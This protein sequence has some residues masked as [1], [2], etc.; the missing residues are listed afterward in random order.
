M[1]FQQHIV[2][3]KAAHFIDTFLSRFFKDKN[4]SED[5]LHKKNILRF[6]LSR[7]I[8]AL[9]C[10]VEKSFAHHKIRFITIRVVCLLNRLINFLALFCELEVFFVYI[11]DCR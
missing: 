10:V 3:K 2:L 1:Q 9:R 5:F 7:R 8:A 4:T 6:V 11:R